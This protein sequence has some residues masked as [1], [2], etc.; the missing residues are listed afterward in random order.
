MPSSKKI[1]RM[2]TADVD[3]AL[4]NIGS[5]KP[6]MKDDGAELKAA[7]AGKK[8]QTFSEA[9][10]AARKDPEAMK[11][12]TF[13]W[14]GKS[15]STKM[16]GE[17]GKSAAAKAAAPT[18]RP[19]ETQAKPATDVSDKTKQF[20]SKLP[21]K[22]KAEAPAAPKAEPKR[23]NT[24]AGRRARMGEVFSRLNPLR[25]R[26][27]TEAL[28]PGLSAEA[29]RRRKA[30]GQTVRPLLLTGDEAREANRRD[31]TIGGYKK[32]GKIDGCAIRGKTRAMRKK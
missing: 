19:A 6:D 14:F 5:V 28:A 7:T 16:A 20:V 9:F 3:K 10:R 32:G 17:G 12:G 27:V 21:L 23:D 15:Y 11:R 13:T 22:P 18:R 29:E 4:A 31:G 25:D 8:A 2:V 1:G 30:A 26:S 24:A